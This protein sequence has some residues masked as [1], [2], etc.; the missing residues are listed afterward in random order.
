MAN[1]A[2]P[3]PCNIG[4]KFEYEGLGHEVSV[5]HIKAYLNKPSHQTDKAVIVIHDVFGWQLPNTRFIADMLT[6][7][8]YIAICPDFYKGQAPWTPSS[9]W[10]TFDDWIKT[11]DSKHI[12]KE[13]DVVLKY[14]KEQCKAKKIGVIG[15]C[16]GGAA[17][18]HL[19]LKYSELK[20]GVSIYGVIKFTEDNCQLKNPT[21]FIFGENDDVIPLDQVRCC[22]KMQN[23]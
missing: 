12:N 23:H 19:M 2:N 6:S 1:E 9:D 15:F 7:N 18:H 21:F 17:V 4:D 14:L 13:A 5:E 8:G 20:A 10:A 16:W 3:C 11:R 22:F